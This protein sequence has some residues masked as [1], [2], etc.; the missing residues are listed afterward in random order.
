MSDTLSWL[1]GIEDKN[2]IIE[3]KYHSWVQCRTIIKSLGK[4]IFAS[5]SIPVI[6]SG[7]KF[8][9]VMACV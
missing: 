5:I 4:I 9:H 3:L 2:I 8:G 6:Q 1:Y 7:H